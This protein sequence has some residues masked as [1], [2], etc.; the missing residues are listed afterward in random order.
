MFVLFITKLM[1]RMTVGNKQMNTIRFIPLRILIRFN[2][3]SKCI[4][5]LM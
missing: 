1:N 5:V 3:E 2:F 4:W